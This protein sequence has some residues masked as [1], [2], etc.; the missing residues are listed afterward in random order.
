VKE[1]KIRFQNV[2]SVLSGFGRVIFILTLS[3][4]NIISLSLPEFTLLITQCL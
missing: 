4:R 2:V 3:Q 1:Q